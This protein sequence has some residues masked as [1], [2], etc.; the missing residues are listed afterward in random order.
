MLTLGAG[1]A[2][3]GPIRSFR[4]QVAAVGGADIDPVVENSDELNEARVRMMGL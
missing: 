3:R 1:P 4:G 2:T